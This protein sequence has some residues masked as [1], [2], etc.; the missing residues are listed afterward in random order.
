VIGACIRWLTDYMLHWLRP[1]A[2]AGEQAERVKTI[3]ER[4]DGIATRVDNLETERRR[5]E[6]AREL[7][8][9]RAIAR[10]RTARQ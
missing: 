4:I 6:R 9:L 1:A 3:K 10:G 5:Q 8:R 2:S 7:A